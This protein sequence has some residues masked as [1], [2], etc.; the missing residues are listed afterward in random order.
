MVDVI[1]L[2]A[3]DD[4]A[5]FASDEKVQ[6]KDEV[7]VEQKVEQKVEV[8]EVEQKV[9][10]KV[11]EKVETKVET[12]HEVIDEI[13]G[14][15][16]IIHSPSSTSLPDVEVK[17]GEPETANAEIEF[18]STAHDVQA[19][20]EDD[21]E[22]ISVQTSTP[23]QKRSF[24]QAFGAPLQDVVE[25]DPEVLQ[26]QEQIASTQQYIDHCHSLLTKASSALQ[27]FEESLAKRKA[28]LRRKAD[29]AFNWLDSFPWDNV[30]NDQLNNVFHISTFRP[31][32]R[33]ALNAT[34]LKRD[35]FAILPTGAGKSLIYQL[36]AVVDGGLTLV[37]TP[38]IS[39]ST[40]QLRSLRLRNIHA[41]S[42]DS[43]TSKEQVK[44]I[45]KNVLS[46]NGDVQG[47]KQP[48]KKRR[49]GR[50]K[51]P[52]H[53]ASPSSWIRD[54][55]S[56]VV[57]FVTP[58]MIAKSKRLVSRLEVMHEA[59]HLSRICIDEAHCCS[60]WG[61]DFRPDYRKLGILRRQ[62]PSTPIIALSATCS[63]ET[64]DDVCQSLE[65]SDC[66]V[67]RGSV[68]RPNIYYEV[69]P[70]PDGD[71]EVQKLLIECI[72]SEFAEQSG[73]IYVL[74]KKEA[75]SYAL[76]LQSAGIQAGCYHG[77][78]Y[79]E[80]RKDTHVQW[81]K[82]EIRVVVAT[83]A[84]GLGIDNHKVRFVIHS[85]MATSVE[86]YYQES[87]RCGR[88]GRKARAILLHSSKDFPRLTAF[89][90]DKGGDRHEK[91]YEMYRYGAAYLGQEIPCRRALIAKAFRQTPPERQE[92]GEHNP[93]Q[94]CDLCRSKVQTAVPSF[95]R[96]DVSKLAK[97]ALRIMRFLESSRPNEK[98]T[99]MS[100]AKLWSRSKDA[101]HW[102]GKHPAISSKIPV[103]TR[104]K[105]LAE[106]VLEDG[107]EEYFRHSSYSV[108]AYV[109]T[110]PKYC[111]HLKDSARFSIVVNLSNAH[112]LKKF[113]DVAE[114]NVNE[115]AC[116][117]EGNECEL[118]EQLL[119]TTETVETTEAPGNSDM[120]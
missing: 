22:F 78:M 109:K 15:D 48:R 29:A 62:C 9:E 34:L 57:L 83:I 100:F 99:M 119:E 116:I 74:S 101:A 76:I 37:V 95:R 108:N 32:Q 40:D 25:N 88:D 8:K 13:I 39:L 71:P 107:L 41:E 31:L 10:Q 86:G 70:K 7:N 115:S 59:G 105:I 112:L 6:A 11:E 97:S 42:L 69:R 102:H 44:R 50:G 12:K 18:L 65:I 30:L 46:A 85:T 45:F 55:M 66:V 61:H 51:Q 81:S 53:K 49:G 52:K 36:A 87:G 96:M 58:E 5:S 54:D 28:M 110:G 20:S 84:F 56:T 43:T 33:E 3:A 117:D 67:F 47:S 92:D 72:Q 120:G 27:D 19:K 79:P 17:P 24:S 118:A 98:W 93:V 1:D 14:G 94:C 114:I 77:D 103:E 113:C 2:C 4:N 68:D 21:V 111:Q 90:A 23:A 38:L 82:G 63:P 73:I 89:V 35:V 60:S 106:L 16:K 26:L 104:L 91:V 80:E 75:E 64:T